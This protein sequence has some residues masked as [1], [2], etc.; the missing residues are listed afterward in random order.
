MRPGSSA[1]PRRGQSLRHRPSRGERC[2][3]VYSRSVAPSCISVHRSQGERHGTGTTGTSSGLVWR[4]RWRSRWKACGQPVML[5]APGSCTSLCT[6][7]FVVRAARVRTWCAGW[8]AVPSARQCPWLTPMLLVQKYNQT[9]R[10]P[11]PH[12]RNLP[13]LAAACTP[14]TRVGTLRWC[15]SSMRHARHGVVAVAQ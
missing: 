5:A 14:H 7:C 12:A 6:V 11:P 15:A 10:L 1:G 4:W 3:L 2:G 9:E 8:G 13:T